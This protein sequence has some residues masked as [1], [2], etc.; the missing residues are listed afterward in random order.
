M[1]MKRGA[2]ASWKVRASAGRRQGRKVCRFFRLVTKSREQIAA[3]DGVGGVL[4]HIEQFG[5]FRPVGAAGEEG[6]DQGR[7]DDAEPMQALP[8]PEGFVVSGLLF[9]EVGVAVFESGEENGVF[10]SENGVFL[11]QG[12]GLSLR[13]RKLLVLQY[14]ASLRNWWAL[15]FQSSASAWN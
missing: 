9:C 10:V 15:S 3:F 5:E 2:N 11:A 1:M 4:G 12:L 13:G 6:V 7:R 14:N 8:F